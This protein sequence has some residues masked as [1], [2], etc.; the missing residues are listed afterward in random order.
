MS[1]E[2]V[3][4]KAVELLKKHGLTIGLGLGGL[5]LA[6]AG[7]FLYANRVE[8]KAYRLERLRLSA[9]RAPVNG[10]QPRTI[11]ILHISDLHLCEPESHKIAFLESLGEE[12][13]DLV[14]LTGDIFQNKSGLQYSS[15]ILKRMPRYGA[16][17][18]FGNHDYYAY[19]M[20]NKT[21]GRL[22]KRLRT[23]RQRRDVQP[24]VEA[25][26]F[27]GFEVLRD[28]S[29]H[30]ER[31]GVSIIGIDYPWTTSAKL[32]SLVRSAPEK[33][34]LVALLHLPKKLDM[35]SDAGIDIGFGGHTHGGQIRIP[36]MGAIITD[37]ELARSEASG[38]VRR[39]NTVFHISRGLGADPRSNIRVF[40]PP[41]ATVIELQY[42]I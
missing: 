40:C 5:T 29:R 7:L 15:R 6:G 1:D 37:S 28:E 34:L 19:N 26:E 32:K 10:A 9:G 38:L 35:V 11:K 39:G 30:I 12:E 31:L 22:I 16:Y 18:V 20:I 36:G 21:V 23:P 42:Y 8:P 13:Y 24:Y 2:R 4:T 27:A 3:T 41:A 33:H 14:F 25:L 17:A